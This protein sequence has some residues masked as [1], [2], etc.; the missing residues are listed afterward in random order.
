MLYLS[1]ALREI[2]LISLHILCSL[3]HFNVLS[4]NLLSGKMVTDKN[5][6]APISLVNGSEMN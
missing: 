3:P 6:R 2:L 4:H 1:A 5:R